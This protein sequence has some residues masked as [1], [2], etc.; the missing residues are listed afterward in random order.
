MRVAHLTTA[1]VR[2]LTVA[3]AAVAL[4][5]ALSAALVAGA[6]EDGRAAGAAGGAYW[7]GRTFEGVPLTSSPGMSYIYGSCTAG[8]DSAC[9]QPLEVRNATTTC[10]RNPVASDLVPSDLRRVV[11][12]RVRGGAILARYP[13]N[14]IDLATGR[15]TVT[16]FPD[17]DVRE[18]A[19]V[20]QLRRRSEQVPAPR[21]AAPRY[22][23]AVLQE[24]KR[25]VLARRGGRSVGA[26]G[27]AIG[28]SRPA[29][30]VRLT[31][32]RL[33]GP[34][35]LRH[36]PAPT[37]SWREVKFAR[38]AAFGARENGE[39][40]TARE[41]GITVARLRRLVRSVRGL[42]GSC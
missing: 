23:R 31:L 1:R 40:S 3:A 8:P 42:T 36:V 17:P 13:I 27:D 12:R 10:A 2:R 38:L 25:V 4:L 21:L 39:R 35:A 32:A 30:R 34:R 19:A 15:H 22:P 18:T 28:L 20:A 41:L 16:L 5:V 11:L 26:I 9:A 7:L 37:R 6:H 14:G 24:L 33:V 29:V